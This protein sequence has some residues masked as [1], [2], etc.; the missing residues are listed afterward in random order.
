MPER[1]R[2]TGNQLPSDSALSHLATI[3]KMM[4]KARTPNESQVRITRA[5][6]LIRI[7]HSSEFARRV[8]ALAA[9]FDETRKAGFLTGF[10]DTLTF[11]APDEEDTREPNGARY[12][13]V[14]EAAKPAQAEVLTGEEFFSFLNAIGK[15]NT[16]EY[17]DFLHGYLDLGKAS[18][19]DWDYADPKTSLDRFAWAFDERILSNKPLMALLNRVPREAA[20]KYFDLFIS[21]TNHD[22]NKGYFEEYFKALTDENFINFLNELPHKA[23]GECL[24]ACR[25]F[26]KVEDPTVGLAV[27]RSAELPRL[28]KGRNPDDADELAQNLFRGIS[29]L[30][31]KKTSHFNGTINID[32]RVYSAE[33]IARMLLSKRVVD[34]AV[35]LGSAA[36]SYYAALNNDKGRVF[37]SNNFF[38][39]AELQ[40]LLNKTPGLAKKYFSAAAEAG[41][42]E[43]INARLASLQMTVFLK[44]LPQKVLDAYVTTLEKSGSSISSSNFELLTDDVI[45]QHKP[46]LDFLKT[47]AYQRVEL[48]LEAFSGSTRPETKVALLDVYGEETFKELGRIEP[49]LIPAWLNAVARTTD[50]KSI[51]YLN[52]ARFWF[53]NENV[54]GFIRDIG[55]AK[56]YEF[57]GEFNSKQ[58]GESAI[59]LADM[60]S[61]KK[62]RASLDK[63]LGILPQLL[64][65]HRELGYLGYDASSETEYLIRKGNRDLIKETA[66][67]V[68][69]SKLV[70]FSNSDKSQADWVSE[71]AG[72]LAFLRSLKES[73]FSDSE[74]VEAIRKVC[75]VAS[76]SSAFSKEIRQALYAPVYAV[77]RKADETA[78]PEFRKKIESEYPDLAIYLRKYNVD[79]RKVYPQLHQCVAAGNKLNF[80]TVKR[81]MQH[82]DLER[83]AEKLRN[84]GTEWQDLS[85]SPARFGRGAGKRPYVSR[86]IEEL[87]NAAMRVKYQQAM[88]L[89]NLDDIHHKVIE[90]FSGKSLKKKEMSPEL[91][92]AVE[93][94]AS[95]TDKG[96]GK[97]SRNLI[98]IYYEKGPK[99][100]ADW[101]KAFDK[102]KVSEAQMRKQG[103]QLDAIRKFKVKTT[104]SGFKSVEAARKNEIE[105]NYKEVIAH[106]DQLREKGL[107]NIEVPKDGGD[108]LSASVSISKKLNELGNSDVVELA[109]SKKVKVTDEMRSIIRD[110]NGHISQI[111]NADGA[112]RVQSRQKDVVFFVP[113]DPVM[114][115]NMG[116]G[117]DSCLNIVRGGNK[118]VAVE[119]VINQPYH[120][121]L[122]AAEGKE[123][124]PVIGRVS[125]VDTDKGFTVHSK[126]YQNTTHKLDDKWIDVLSRFSK[127][128]RSNVIIPTK[129]VNPQMQHKLES[130]G[131]QPQSMALEG[132]YNGPLPDSYSD[133]NV[134]NGKQLTDAY[135][136]KPDAGIRRT[137]VRPRTV[138]HH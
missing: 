98:S 33:D 65:F 8:E 108:W 29:D 76:G 48:F 16:S 55:P 67:L 21:K 87:D 121:T 14:V 129:F 36:S 127:T 24:D 66:S 106:V 109:P 95:I 102:N 35:T 103:I 53:F 4:E 30:R 34:Y 131:L 113:K 137:S 43:G 23:I 110:I 86:F 37:S 111:R 88:K 94:A 5:L 11:K 138:Q 63:L 92:N 27:L 38:E 13:E 1:K 72:H 104:V 80:S 44:S 15:N 107:T 91:K 89:L 56:A 42:H 28:F 20:K 25:S 115:L 40:K 45:I 6:D 68:K 78:M 46:T 118:H 57:M 82:V 75:K 93:G 90:H 60:W 134:F 59:F 9:G 51:H 74:R 122:L 73:V 69:N 22:L 119:R 3:Q 116:T 54:K 10:V 62:K 100:A 2:V 117:F 123:N 52:P 101:I 12:V 70:L 19:Y 17:V 50:E 99:A 120:A 112:L 49:Q 136:F 61:D 130:M 126:F 84:S 7:L 77:Y 105:Q 31:E 64:T 71:N 124:G 39:N 133:F 96:S 26:S 83:V 47:A 85:L 18:T 58:A 132:I 32:Q 81:D 97:L 128:A 41:N 114:A 125:L 79:F 135:V